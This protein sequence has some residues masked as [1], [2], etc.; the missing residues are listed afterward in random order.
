MADN[1]IQIGNVLTLITPQGGVLSGQPFMV[2]SIFA[3]ATTSQKAGE[4]VE[5][6]ITG[7][8]ELPKAAGQ[9]DQGDPIFFVPGTGLVGDSAP[10]GVLIGAA[11]ARAGADDA[12]V[13]V[14]LNGVTLPAPVGA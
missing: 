10:T 9:L 11:V 1:Y 13:R 6:A 7:V 5:G 3:V 4:E 12:T 2:G 14:R 8:W